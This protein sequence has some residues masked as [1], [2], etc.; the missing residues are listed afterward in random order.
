M[1]RKRQAFTIA[2]PPNNDTRRGL[3]F[4]TKPSLEA[5]R[6]EIVDYRSETGLISPNAYVGIPVAEREP[7]SLLVVRQFIVDSM[8]LVLDLVIY[9]DDGRDFGYL[10]NALA[11]AVAATS[12]FARE[13]VSRS[14]DALFGA[15]P[16][17]EKEIS[18]D[19]SLI[20]APILFPFAL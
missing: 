8:Q 18:V 3:F 10:N 13:A 12:A 17:Y 16:E 4:E 11:D 2:Q 9:R 19:L 7:I 15:L 6:E 14:I 20:I 5:A 1:A